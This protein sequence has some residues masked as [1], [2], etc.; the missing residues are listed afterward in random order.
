MPEIRWLKIALNV[1]HIVTHEKHRPWNGAQEKQITLLLS[2]NG[3]CPQALCIPMHTRPVSRIQAKAFRYQLIVSVRPIFIFSKTHCP[4]K[5]PHLC[6]LRNFGRDGLSPCFEELHNPWPFKYVWLY[7]MVYMTYYGGMEF[8]NHFAPVP[9]LVL[10]FV[11]ALIFGNRAAKNNCSSMP[12]QDRGL[13]R[14][15]RKPADAYCPVAKI[16]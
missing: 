1:N 12:T 10:G 15:R 9:S 16:V 3:C 11:S 2:A 14:P 6:R 4:D 7:V 13:R 8:A 5:H